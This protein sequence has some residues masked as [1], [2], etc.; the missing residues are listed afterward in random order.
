[1]K[2][3]SHIVEINIVY[4][5]SRRYRGRAFSSRYIRRVNTHTA[6]YFTLNSLYHTGNTT[7]TER[8]TIL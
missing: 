1:M 4:V 7:T 3:L 2:F 5:Y 6:L 8:V